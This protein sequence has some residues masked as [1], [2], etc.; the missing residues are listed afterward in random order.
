LIG[1]DPFEQPIKGPLTRHV[2]LAARS[3]LGTAAQ[4][5]SLTVVET[6][7]KLR[8]RVRSL[9]T[10]RDRQGGHRDHA[11]DGMTHPRRIARVAYVLAQRLRQHR[12]AQFVQRL[13]AQR[14]HP[15]LL[16]MLRVEVEVLATPFKPPRPAQRLPVRRSITGAA[17][18]LRIDERLDQEHGLSELVLPVLRQSRA[19]QL[20]HA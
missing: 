3:A 12:R 8:D 9:A 18:T 11:D 16:R 20:E 2:E 15:Q 5:A 4:A 19:R 7:G 13:P 10:G 1:V 6:L 17:K 14:I